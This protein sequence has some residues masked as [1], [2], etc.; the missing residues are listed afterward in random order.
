MNQIVY[1]INRISDWIQKF[2]LA[3]GGV[4]LVAM[5][6]IAGL[7]VV[8][9]FILHNSLSWTQEVDSYLFVWLTC[10]GAAIGYKLRAHPQVVVLVDRLPGLFKKGVIAF[11]DLIVLALGVLLMFYGGKMIALMGPETA[12]SIKVSMIY[13]YLAIPVGGLGL[14][15]HAINHILT[16][17]VLGKKH[18]SLVNTENI[19]GVGTWE[20]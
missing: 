18:S 7:G 9:R 17:L 13:P 3:I 20:H 2:S 8:Y 11:G 6:I 10:L 5:V 1:A 15:I 19:K 4:I 14:C 12:S 16:D